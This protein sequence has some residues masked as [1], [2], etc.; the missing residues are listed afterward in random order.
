M[1]FDGTSG[2]VVVQGQA[3]SRE[4]VTALRAAV[5]G[6][7]VA[8]QPALLADVREEQEGVVFRLVIPVATGEEGGARMAAGASTTE[9]GGE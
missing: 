2:K 1:A 4:A 5:D 8:A 9:G 6:S 3:L 7:G